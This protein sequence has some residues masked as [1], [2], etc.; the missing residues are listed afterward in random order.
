[1]TEEK[2][3]KITAVKNSADLNKLEESYKARIAELEQ[4]P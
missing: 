2:Q 3:E 4:K 1:M